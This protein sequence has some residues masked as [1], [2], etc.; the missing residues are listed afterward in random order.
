VRALTVQ[1]PHTL[2]ADALDNRE[3][4][5]DAARAAFAAEGLDVPM[6]E[7]ARRAGV[8]PATLYRR[9]P[10]KET[11]ATEAFADEMRGCHAILD[12]GL[13]DP[14]AW[15]GFCLAIEK[16]CELHARNQGF[17][18]AF[19]ST[20]PGALDLAADRRSGLSSL[21]ELSRRAKDAGRLRHDVALDDLILVL[22]ANRGIRAGSTAA[23]VAASRRFAALMIRGFEAST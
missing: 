15:H 12:E 4:I 18:A 5:L 13:A 11:L 10:T 8:A 22:M 9:F 17:T 16:L 3:R 6:R 2:R 14:D 7:I 21:A 23:R 19:L 20:F 1:L